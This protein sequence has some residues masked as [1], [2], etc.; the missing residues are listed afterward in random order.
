[1]RRAL[2]RGKEQVVGI[3][4]GEVR[5]E[6]QKDGS[7]HSSCLPTK[8]ASALK[9]GRQGAEHIPPEIAKDESD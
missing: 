8:R 7:E 3:V 9:D 4:P 2:T 5:S 1:M 6:R